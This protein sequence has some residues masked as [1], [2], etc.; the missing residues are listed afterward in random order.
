MTGIEEILALDETAPGRFR[1]AP[2]PSE[3]PRTFGGQVAAQSLVAAARTVDP[4]YTAHSSHGN[5]L[6]PGRPHEPA[7]HV[8]ERLRDGGSF[9]TRRVTGIQAGD[10]VFTMTVSFHRG[11]EGFSHQAGMP[12]VPAPEEIAASDRATGRRVARLAEWREWDIRWVPRTA[13]G[14]VPDAPACQRMWIRYGRPLPDDPVLHAGALTYLSDMALLRT[15]RL[16]HPERAVQGA[17]LDH[18][19]WFLRP[20][21]ADEWLLYDQV[22]PSAEL[23]RALIRGRLFDRTG[24]LVAAA[25]KEGLMRYDRRRPDTG[26]SLEG[27]TTGG[28]TSGRVPAG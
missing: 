6:A 25:V 14:R 9:C 20:F 2:V 21:R 13:I 19:V 15:S 3:L 7:D 1:S 12:D 5:F 23:G 16:P 28:H 4:A 11:D 10:A 27:G 22:S 24:R 8:V 17:S 26:G 18:S